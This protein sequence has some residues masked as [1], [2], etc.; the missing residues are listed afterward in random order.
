MLHLPQRS[1]YATLALIELAHRWGGEAVSVAEIAA[2]RGIPER[3]L[4]SI[5]HTLR[6]SGL[7]TSVRGSRGGFR[8]ARAP[9]RITLTEVL[10][11]LGS[12]PQGDGCPACGEQGPCARTPE[13]ALRESIGE[14]AR[15]VD[16]VLTRTNLADLARREIEL[17]GKRAPDF[18]I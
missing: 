2:R 18:V 14:A 5:L 15:A 3:F 13:C 8:L 11:V 9:E 1:H 17:A 4:A 10:G 12:Q 6:G 7:V 16:A